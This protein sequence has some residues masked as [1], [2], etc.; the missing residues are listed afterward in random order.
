MPRQCFKEL[1][2]HTDL[3]PTVPV[4]PVEENLPSYSLPTTER[5]FTIVSNSQGIYI[6]NASGLAE[7]DVIQQIE[8]TTAKLGDRC[9]LC[10]KPAL[11]VDSG[12]S[13]NHHFV[14]SG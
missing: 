10:G 6:G 14:R 8:F 7:A 9:P 13:I 11:V 2:I 5:Q 1:Q 3:L 4:P 12:Y